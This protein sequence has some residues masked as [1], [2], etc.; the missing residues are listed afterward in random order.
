MT[1]GTIDDEEVTKDVLG[2]YFSLISI[3]E[4]KELVM[5]AFAKRG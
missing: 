5:D 2:N 4:A 1:D 3:K